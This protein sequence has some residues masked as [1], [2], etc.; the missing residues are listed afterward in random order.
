MN[1]AGPSPRRSP[2]VW[3]LTAAVH[4]YRVA[5]GWLGSGIS[6]CRYT[7]TCSAYALEALE[8]HGAWRGAKLTLRR[9][10]H[11]HPWAEFGFDP[12][13]EASTQHA[14]SPAAPTA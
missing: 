14:S 10:A 2:A 12:V 6:P 4:L 13:P 1:P 7:P 11:C 8:R 3:L 5:R 9:L